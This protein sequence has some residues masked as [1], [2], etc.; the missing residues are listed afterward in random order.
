MPPLRNVLVLGAYG[1]IGSHVLAHLHAHDFTLTGA[2]RD[3]RVATRRFPYARWI[4]IDLA[5]LQTEADW[6]PHLHNIDAVINCAGALQDS[7]RDDL[8]AIHVA[9]TLALYRACQQAGV[10]RIV[11]VSAA[12]VAPGRATTFNSTKLEADLA[13]QQLD[14]DW[15]ILRPGLVL[16]PTAYGGSALL[17]GLAGFPG[18]IPAVHADSITQVVSV[19]DVAEAA[20]RSLQADAPLRTVIDLVHLDRVALSDVLLRLRAWLGVPPAPLRAVPPI[21]ARLT[22]WAGDALA[23]LGWRSPMRSTAIAQLRDAITGDAQGW[24]HLHMRPASLDAMLAAWPSGVQERWFARLYFVKPAAL[25]AL[26]VFWLLSGLI[27]FVAHDSAVCVLTGW[28]MWL[29]STAVISGAIVDITLAGLVAFR[30]TAKIGLI[31]M[32]LVS[33]AYLL[34]GTLVRPDLWLDPLGPLVKVLPGAV[35]ALAALG[36]LDE[37]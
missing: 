20:R 34:G 17:R 26:V 13:L 35:L 8:H 15:I 1:F 6:L 36:M 25:I 29:A 9:G 2:G 31:G 4:N 33:A 7:P 32:L 19:Q 10:R 21:L 24:Q 37:R 16:G 12:G 22:G 30:R 27:G 18:M 3:I 28:P 5:Q 23:W 11:H 14:L